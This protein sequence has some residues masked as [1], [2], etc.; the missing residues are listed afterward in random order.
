MEFSVKNIFISQ[1]HVTVKEAKAHINFFTKN[2]MSK[3]N[4]SEF[5][6]WMAC[7]QFIVR[8]FNVK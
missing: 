4:K 6:V 8:H 5:D 7:A 2:C 3:P 1:K